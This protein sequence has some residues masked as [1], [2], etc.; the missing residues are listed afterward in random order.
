MRKKL[1]V[2]RVL[3]GIS[4]TGLVLG[5]LETMVGAYIGPVVVTGCAIGVTVCVRNIRRI[6]RVLANSKSE[7]A[8][9]RAGETDG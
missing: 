8:N 2:E 6:N 1:I 9:G 7:G 5:V 3:L 4:V